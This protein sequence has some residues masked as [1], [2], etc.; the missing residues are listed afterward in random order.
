MGAPRLA[1]S[2]VA[3]GGVV[4]LVTYVL[5]IRVGFRERTLAI[6][7]VAVCLNVTWE[8]TH[9]LIYRPPRPIDF[10]TNLFWLALDLVIVYQ[11]FR[12]GGRLQ[13]L[14]ALRR[15]YPGV[16]AGTLALSLAGHITF[17]EH[18]IA[19]SI[20]PDT[21]GAIPAFIINLVMSVL[22]V[23]MYFSRPDGAGLSRGVAWGKFIGSSL[24][25]IGNTMVLASVPQLRYGVQIQA[26]G[27]DT[28]VNAGTV[29]TATIHPGFLYFLFIATAAFDLLYLWLLHRPRRSP[30]GAG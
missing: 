27:S 18:V 3:L 7:L 21:S 19:N 14:P 23:T 25:A 20:F 2:L 13:A 16:V 26:P 4:W 5:A 24:Y 8:L 9:S 17:H 10:Y 15:F 30:A 1:L 29:G 12:F 6:P 28:W 22:F 11:V